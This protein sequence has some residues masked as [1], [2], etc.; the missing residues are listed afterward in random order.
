[1]SGFLGTGGYFLQ[2]VRYVAKRT[3][4]G[5]LLLAVIVTLWAFVQACD[6]AIT[7]SGARVASELSKKPVKRWSF[8]P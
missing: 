2:R 3:V 6:W 1:M 8:E 7:E 4:E 5:L